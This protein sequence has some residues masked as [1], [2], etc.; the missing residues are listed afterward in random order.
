[1]KN[2]WKFVS[3]KNIFNQNKKTIWI[4]NKFRIKL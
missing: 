2:K 1:M 4:A 3:V